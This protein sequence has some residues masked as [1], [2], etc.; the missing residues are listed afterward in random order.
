MIKNIHE[1][2]TGNRF[3]AVDDEE[4]TVL[5]MIYRILSKCDELIKGHNILEELGEL[6]RNEKVSKEDMKKIYKLFPNGDFIGSWHGIEK[7]VFSEPGIAGVV[8]KLETDF[9]NL[10]IVNVKSFGAKGD[11]TTDDTLSIQSANDYCELH[12]KFLFFPA[13][14]YI[15]SDGIDKSCDWYGMGTPT[16]GTFP[17]YDDKIYLRE[18]Y[19]NKL[20]GSVLLFTGEGKK[21]ISTQRTDNFGSITYCVKAKAGQSY[22]LDNMAIVLD[23][24]V[25][26]DVG[27]FTNPNDDNHADY[28]CG[29]LIDDGFRNRHRNL[30]VFGYFNKAG[31]VVRSVEKTNYLGD[32]DY[33]VFNGGSVSGDYGIALIG[34]NCDDD[35]SS[36]L[37]GTRF[38]DMQIFAKDHHS[39]DLNFDKWGKGCIYIDG[40]TKANNANIN[41]QYFNNCGI[42]TYATN[43]L[44]LDQASNISFNQ[45]VFETPTYGTTNSQ[46][47]QFLASDGTYD[48]T[49]N[50]CRFSD[51]AGINNALFSGNITKLVVIGEPFDDIVMCNK[52][53]GIRLGSENNKPF[54]QFTTE[55][56]SKVKGFK[57][58][59]DLENIDIMKD[60]VS[61]LKMFSDGSIDKAIFKHGGAKTINDNT[62]TIGQLSSYSLTVGNSSELN[63]INGGYP[64]QRLHLKTSTST[65]TVTLTKNGNIRLHESITLDNIFDRVVLE[66]DGTYWV[67][68]SYSNNA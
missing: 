63:T 58:Q 4:F 46:K 20:R 66:Y 47:T 56:N 29:Y 42:R 14:V 43:P 28:D 61:I 31:I 60:N 7:P 8:D 2:L 19:K 44:V 37:S 22:I 49:F 11:G 25:L 64:G 51:G 48:V 59:S 38:I 57:I 27:N 17:I 65:Q 39:R 33:N 3:I 18:G 50:Q 26:D 40:Y 6:L 55:L 10:N 68:I 35:V 52:G 13:G 41:G 67:L 53:Y 1:G 45:C 36:G 23:M 24:N 30:V 15:C 16:L 62:I 21:K 32:P 54:L 5:E 12:N 34:S 9:R